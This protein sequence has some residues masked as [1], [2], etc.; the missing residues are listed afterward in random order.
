[1]TVVSYTFV[2]LPNNIS[3]YLEHWNFLTIG[4]SGWRCFPIHNG[5]WLYIDG[6]L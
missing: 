1:L 4:N 2:E 6:I 3:E 5:S